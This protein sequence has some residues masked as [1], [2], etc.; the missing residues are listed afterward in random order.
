MGASENNVQSRVRL[1]G[2]ELKMRLFRNNRG[3]FKDD[4]GRW[5]RYGLANDSKA[6]GDKIKS[7]DLIGWRPVVITPD[8]VG[9]VIAQFVS[10]ECKPEGWTP[11]REG[12]LEFEEYHKPQANWATHVNRDGGYAIFVTDPAQLG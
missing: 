1:R 5:I 8:M 12:T 4:D 7:G 11:P 10:L 6:L 2:T 3:A 9:K